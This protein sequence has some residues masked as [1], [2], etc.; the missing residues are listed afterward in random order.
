MK[1]PIIVSVG[2]GKGGIGKSTVTSYLGA[3]LSNKGCSVG[4]VDADLG[5]ANLHNF[6]G[7]PRPRSGLQDFLSGRAG[8]LEEIIVKTP[9][10]HTWLISGASDILELAN[11]KFSQK[12]RLI[13]NLKKMDADYIFVDLGAGTSHHVT[14]FYASFPYGIIVSDSLPISIENA[15]GFLKNGVLR[16]LTR[17][18]P[19]NRDVVQFIKRMSDPKAEKGFST[20]H[21]ML[22][23]A[24][25][26]F[27]EECRRMKE[28]LFWKKNFLVLNMVREEE[29][30]RVG[31]RFMD[32]V[33]KYLSISLSYIGYI[34]Y[35][36]EF[37]AQLRGPGPAA[38]SASKAISAC[39]E[40]IASNLCALTKG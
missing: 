11:P 39:F 35:E 17:L 15:Y 13:S 9:I 23:A 40:A 38:L 19:G 16:G 27:P 8:T 21:E 18:F 10:A 34:S 22:A 37:R 3:T 26:A 29:D 12:Q 32:M 5:G 2:G 6:V 33:K 25:T 28:W 1:E 4:F 20:V 30:I 36:P 24:S 14:D 7:V 31:R